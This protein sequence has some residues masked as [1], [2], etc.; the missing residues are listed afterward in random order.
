VPEEEL[1]MARYEALGS[2][3]APEPTL[4]LREHAMVSA[5]LLEVR[6]TPGP[7]TAALD[8]RMARAEILEKYDLDEFSWSIEERA[9]ADRL[10]TIPT[11]TENN[12]HVEYARH[13]LAA[14]ERLAPPGEALPSPKDYATITARL[15]VQQPR[16][17]L[18]DAKLSLGA[19]MRI[20][21]KYQDK[22]ATDEALR[23]EVD[24]WLD[25]ASGELGDPV[26][27]EVDDE[28]VIQ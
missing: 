1:E 26:I 14:Q 6:M 9:H 3:Q 28:G 16:D 4:D 24:K 17:V 8:E 5:E 13:F 21:R 23:N 25:E 18:H 22:M 7:T 20:D 10:A 19:W 27:P 2:F 12:L 11:D 15:Q